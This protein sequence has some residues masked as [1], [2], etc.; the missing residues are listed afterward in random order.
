VNMSA[1]ACENEFSFNPSASPS[2]TAEDAGLQQDGTE[3]LAKCF[4]LAMVQ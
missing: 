1:P 2:V 3:I 4:I